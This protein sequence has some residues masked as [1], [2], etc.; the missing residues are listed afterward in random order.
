VWRSTL[1][2]VIPNYTFA[3]LN[4]CLQLLTVSTVAPAVA[5]NLAKLIWPKKLDFIIQMKLSS[6]CTSARE[7]C[8]HAVGDAWNS[9][10]SPLN[11]TLIMWTAPI[12]IELRLIDGL[13]SAPDLKLII[14]IQFCIKNAIEQQKTNENKYLNQANTTFQSPLFS[15]HHFPCISTTHLFSCILS[16]H[17]KLYTC[18]KSINICR[19]LCAPVCFHDA[20]RGS[21]VAGIKYIICV[22]IAL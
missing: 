21:L 13:R 19:L 16:L 11:S 7:N 9:A 6:F 12:I 14:I 18:T 1:W 20:P 5:K 17:R 2:S 3:T 10:S 22:I 15:H 4:C 8:E